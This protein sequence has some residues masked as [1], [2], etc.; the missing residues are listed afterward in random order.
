MELSI[1]TIWV[2]SSARASKHLIAI[3]LTIILS[4]NIFLKKKNK[5]PYGLSIILF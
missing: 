2:K 4:I 1:Y 3:L 5:Y